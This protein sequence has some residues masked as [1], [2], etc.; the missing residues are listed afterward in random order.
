M[1]TSILTSS[2]TYRELAEKYDIDP[3]TIRTIC[4]KAKEGAIDALAATPGRNGKTA[5]QLELE[6]ARREIEKLKATICE[7]AMEL[8]LE[9]G[10][11][12]WD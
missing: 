1:F 4:K 5:T 9:R 3:S 7:Q 6:Q 2:A 10:K 11:D 8:H 12:G